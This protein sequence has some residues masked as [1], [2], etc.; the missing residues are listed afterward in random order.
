MAQ[1]RLN[2]LAFPQMSKELPGIFEKATYPAT[3]V[4]EI[5]IAGLPGVTVPAGRFSGG[6][7]FSLIFV[8]PMWSE[9][10]LLGLAFAHEQATHHRVVPQLAKTPYEAATPA[11]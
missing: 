8:G 4:S 11:N 10:E 6:S 2:A 3:T 5:N 1:H 7:P 9:A